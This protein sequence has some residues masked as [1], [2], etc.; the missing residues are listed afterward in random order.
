MKSSTN[1]YCQICENEKRIVEVVEVSKVRKSIKSNIIKEYPKLLNSSGYICMSCLNAHRRVHTT[2]SLQLE[3]G[4]LIG[5]DQEVIDS[6]KDEEKLVPEIYKKIDHESTMGDRVADKT[7]KFGGSWWFILIL[8]AILILNI[9]FL[10]NR[11]F[12]PFPFALLTLVLSCLA[13]LQAPVIMMSQNRQ[14]TK[15]RKRAEQ[16]YHIN[17]KAELEI[18]KVNEKLNHLS[19]RIAD[20]M[21]TQQIQT[22]MIEEFVEIHDDSIRRL[23]TIQE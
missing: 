3:K 19:D 6:M 10:I 23:E 12:D 13:A 15:D 11:P 2:D 16:E 9:V 7:A 4:A 5:L 18:Q 8:P 17:L 22:E 20:L 1:V 21:E 14:D